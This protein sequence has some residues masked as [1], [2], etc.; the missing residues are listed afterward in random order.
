MP[1]IKEGQEINSSF[2]LLPH[3]PPP[4]PVTHVALSFPSPPTGDH[5]DH[6]AQLVWLIVAVCRLC[7]WQDEGTS[8]GCCSCVS[9]NRSWIQDLWEWEWVTEEEMLV[10]RGGR[11]IET[12]QDSSQVRVATPVVSLACASEVRA[13]KSVL[14]EWRVTYADFSHTNCSRGNALARLC[15]IDRLVKATL[16]ANP[17]IGI[18]ALTKTIQQETGVPA[19]ISTATRAGSNVLLTETT[20]LAN[21]YHDIPG[22]FQDLY[23][24]SPGSIAVIDAGS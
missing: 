13:T 24:S 15:G 12:E 8:F 10:I 6:R 14:G 19:S 2:D 22:D 7:I 16:S 21:S 17:D 1:E 20:E 11:T 18:K 23:D 5:H 4:H 9:G 3:Q